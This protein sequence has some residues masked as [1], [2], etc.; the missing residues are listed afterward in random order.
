MS[1]TFS[2]SN[3]LGLG[4]FQLSVTARDS[5]GLTSTAVR[6]FTRVD[7]DTS[8]PSISFTNAVN[9]NDGQDNIVGWNISDSSGIAS[10][11]VRLYS[12]SG[13]GGPT[14]FSNSS[15]NSGSFNL[16]LL[17]PG[18]YTIS[19]T[20]TDDDTD[21]GVADRSSFQSMR[22]FSI[23]D[24]DTSG[25]IISLVSPSTQ[26]QGA[27]ASANFVLSENIASRLSSYTARLFV[28]SSSTQA[29]PPIAVTL[30]T[31]NGSGP[32]SF[33]DGFDM[34]G[35]G[36]GTYR[37]EVTASNNDRDYGTPDIESRSSTPQFITIFNPNDPP[38]AND[39]ITGEAAISED[40]GDTDI[41]NA[42]LA[43]DSDPD[44]DAFSVVEITDGVSTVT[45]SAPGSITLANGAIVSLDGS[46]RVSFDP[47]GQFG[48]L[49]SSEFG[50]TSSFDYTIADT[51]G[52][53]DT[54][55]V[56]VTI[57]GVN[58]Q[59]FVTASGPYSLDENRDVG[60]VV[61]SVSASDVDAIDTNL[62][63]DIV[64]GNTGGAF[65]ID[66][67][68][69]QISV[70]NKAAVDFETNPSFNL[71]IE[72]D[73]NNGEANSTNTS[74]V[75][76]ELND[77]HATL[78]MAMADASGE[79][80]N[81]PIVFD[82]T[83]TGDVINSP[84]DVTYSTIDGTAQNAVVGVG[85]NDYDGTASSTIGFSGDAT[86][87]TRQ[88]SVAVNDESVV[89]TDENF[90][91]NLLA[92]T[93]NDVSFA[94]TLG[95]AVI[96]QENSGPYNGSLAARSIYT[97]RQEVVSGIAGQLDGI[98]L[99]LTSPG[100]LNVA[101][102]L[103]AG[104]QSDPP[105]FSNTVSS[106]T[107]GR[108]FIDTSEAE[109]ILGVGDTFVIEVTGSEDGVGLEGS[110]FSP[111]PGRYPGRLFV[112]S[113][114]RPSFDLRFRSHV[115]PIV[116]A[117]SATGTIENDDFAPIA[118]VGQP[119]VIN[120][121]DG[122]TLDALASTDHDDAVAGLTFRWDVDG[123][124]DFDENVTGVNPTLT[125]AQMSVLG[126]AD[127]PHIIDV[128]VEASDGTNIDTATTTL[129]IENVNPTGNADAGDVNEDGPATT[130]AV[131]ANDTD[132]AGVNDPLSVTAVDTSGTTGS[133]SFTPTDVSYDPNGQF[134]SLDDGATTTDSFEYTVSDGDGGSS[135]GSVTV[136]IHGQNDAP[137]AYPDGSSTNENDAVTIDVLANDSD[138]DAGD[139][140]SNFTLD[141][142]S[143]VS[144]AE[145]SGSPTAAGSASIVNNQLVF[146]PGS[147]YD[148]LAVGETATVTIDYTMSD[149]SGSSSASTAVVTIRGTNDAPVIG[150]LA[151]SNSTPEVKSTDGQV[152]ING[153]FTDLDLS[154]VHSV[155]VDWGDG[156]PVEPATVDQEADTFAAEHQYATGGVFAI[157][158]T[159]DDGNG[160]IDTQTTSAASQGVGLV[161]GVLYII[162]TD[163]RDHVNLRLNEKKDELKVDVK[164]DQ[165]SG[166]NINETFA[167]H[168]VDQ[169]VTYLCGGDD[170]YN[171]DGDGGNGGIGAAAE[172]SQFVFGGDG[173]DHLSGGNGSDVLS[174]GAGNDDLF[175]R[176]GSD[177]LIG[178][179]GRDKVKGGD[180]DDLL[181]GGSTDS[182]SKLESI[183]AALADWTNGD[184][185]AAMVD[186]GALTDDGD[187]DDLKGESGDDEFVGGTG[188]K[189]FP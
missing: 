149:D 100:E 50:T 133:V 188:D 67:T 51:S 119:Y 143:I 94:N 86:S 5:G 123:D 173:N 155:T 144:T 102:N 48:S 174:G 162:G 62:T 73:D 183:E 126:L 142:A 95:T 166:S 27:G 3:S 96:D 45:T 43:N 90:S 167:M 156:S 84:F 1:H 124:G 55:S 75:A 158:V 128:T 32:T 79:E 11:A 2:I 115:S 176:S 109:I 130:F 177:I 68:T 93:S 184:L 160:G 25:P 168:A 117:Q 26:P 135:T 31:A 140:P 77:L 8:G 9:Q 114:E 121:G 98:D 141:S 65:A 39:D 83:L 34:S 104:V 136:T 22:T 145:L 97:W 17:S 28:G 74:I 125:P 52:E 105:E 88:I 20:A 165:G 185:A 10:R 13:T 40:A 21:R 106:P 47:N 154:D 131:L 76:I 111:G 118:H 15:S 49:G 148:E 180:D 60:F 157:T 170:H 181:I 30:A 107:S 182:E 29:L 171:G 7:D 23:S 116:S 152:A 146:D 85:S 172:I 169:I 87:E 36:P 134:E 137:V 19:A 89:E 78:A 112:D 70:A 132:P 24:D 101:I 99:Y 147:D 80:A 153:N 58:D 12:G 113:I 161:D 37:L 16:N 139:N 178:G 151:S 18:A 159:V 41:T 72:V 129:T 150:S 14:I 127:G 57:N 61:G 71:T 44:G 189:L 110:Y 38:V 179:F 81:G 175:G 91:V 69:G 4:T 164:L 42:I 64:G 46:G 138:V 187:R 66:A 92:T 122:L 59:P 6:T 120:E 53:T 82:V 163:G 108:V 186:L 56:N 103:G 35:L 54:A 33:S 63:F